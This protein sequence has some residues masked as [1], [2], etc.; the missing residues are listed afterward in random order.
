MPAGAEGLAEM[1]WIRQTLRRVLGFAASKAGVPVRR[2]AR[3]VGALAAD[4]V[5]RIKQ[6]YR[7]DKYFILGYP[8]SGTTLL[9]RLIRLHADVHC[10]WQG[11]FFTQH[12]SLFDFMGTVELEQW[13]DRR[14]NH[15][16]NGG[17]SVAEM[18]RWACD[19]VMEPEAEALGKK[20][21]GDKSPDD[22][23]ASKLDAMHRVYPDAKI[24]YI[25]RDGRDVAVSRRFQMFIDLPHLLRRRDRKIVDRLQAAGAQNEVYPGS[26]FTVS[27]L[28]HEAE[29][30]A[31]DTVETDILAKNLYGEAYMCVRFE[32]L[33]RE[34]VSCM[35]DVWE[36]LDVGSGRDLADKVLKE[37]GRNPAAEWH[38]EVA[39]NL[40]SGFGRGLAGGWRNVFKEGD[41]LTFNK[42]AGWALESW[43][44]ET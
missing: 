6:V 8:R 13:L 38:T 7:R 3:V 30:W 9:A 1:K 32:T 44:Y 29:G 20:V 14:D 43:G 22:D 31:N 12:D 36:F 39:P 33:V 10:N 41:L 4:D 40:V 34:P 23:T 15:W 28:E 42:A 2:R 37:M 24:I 19:S 25:L 18:I 5:E 26:V 16:A 21:V 17:L 11:H 35:A 27:W